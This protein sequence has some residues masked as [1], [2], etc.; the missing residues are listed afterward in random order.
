MDNPDGAPLFRRGRTHR[1]HRAAEALGLT[2]P[3]ASDDDILDAMVEH[4]ILVERPIVATPKVVR[5]CRPSEAVYALLDTP[6]E[7]FVKEDGEVVR[8]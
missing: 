4:P 6:P 3:A 5:L 1:R 8:R 7:T 2:A